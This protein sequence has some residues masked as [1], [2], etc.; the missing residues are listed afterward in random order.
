MKRLSAFILGATVLCLPPAISAADKIAKFNGTGTWILDPMKS[1]LRPKVTTR[2]DEG[3]IRPSRPVT[4]IVSNPANQGVS[5]YPYGAGS[6]GGYNDYLAV[7]PQICYSGKQLPAAILE[8]CRKAQNTYEQRLAEQRLVTQRLAAQRLVEQRLAEQRFAEQRKSD[9]VAGSASAAGVLG[10]AGAIDS[11]GSIIVIDDA[12]GISAADN[13]SNTGAVYAALGGAGAI[14]N[15]GRG[16]AQ[17][18][19]PTP[20]GF[21]PPSANAA[22]D[23]PG[24]LIIEQLGDSIRITDNTGRQKAVYDYKYGKY[25]ELVETR[26]LG[27]M[28]T[29]HKE[30][31]ANWTKDTIE[32][33]ETIRDHPQGK[34]TTK[35]SIVLSKGGKILT[36]TVETVLAGKDSGNQGYVK[37]TGL[38]QVFGIGENTEK[39]EK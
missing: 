12:G 14:D 36:M 35:K 3:V 8:Q 19:R 4:R 7:V 31:R 6:V 25:S 37:T 29:A 2:Y 30:I 22:N 13:K 34:S 32:I 20:L 10:G 27:I 38:K 39:A 17:G 18:I 9:M 5:G 21:P 11:G 23:K 28:V 15:R 33:T 1:D 16:N 26:N 24:P